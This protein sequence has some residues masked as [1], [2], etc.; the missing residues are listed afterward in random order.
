VREGAAEGR[1]QKAEGRTRA[2][3]SARSL[4]LAY[5]IAS[6][7]VLCA[8]PLDP[9][10][11]ESFDAAWRIVRDTYYDTTFKGHDWDAVRREVRPRAEAAETPDEVRDAIRAMLSRLGDSHLTLLPGGSRPQ[12]APARETSGD[13]GLDV[14]YQHEDRTFLVV[15]VLRESGAEAAGIQPGWL[16]RAIDG[17]PLAETAARAAQEAPERAAPLEMW[18]LVTERLRGA[19]GSRARLEFLDGRNQPREVFALRG[20]ERGERITLGTFPPMF[21]R[22]ERR[23]MQSPSGGRVG[24]IRFNVWLTPV[25][26]FVAA[27]VDEYRSADGIV[28]D[29]RGNPGG[30]AAMLMGIAGQ[31]VN[32]RVSLGEM[33]TRE[34]TLHFFANPRLVAPDGRA[35]APFAGR[36]AILVDSLTGSASECFAGGMQ[37]IGR[38][39][40]FGTKTMGQALPALFDKLPSGD[41]LVHAYADFVTATGA[42][43]EGTGVVPDVETPWSRAALVEGRDTALEQAVLWAGGA[44]ADARLPASD[45]L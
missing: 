3:A 39:R 19:I 20:A 22:T 24:Y 16:L 37:S 28:I 45:G 35:V 34:G 31:F 32:E 21:V 42:R 4:P 17:T 5:A 36:V 27:A 23:A 30:L 43:V 11:L 14:R 6:A 7:T 8:A 1:R 26:S 9:V 33:R 13:P 18:R 2:A 38:A 29:L 15:R 12:G 25:D 44:P 41:V 10:W 40:V